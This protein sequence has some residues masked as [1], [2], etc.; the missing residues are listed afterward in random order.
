M[1]NRALAVVCVMLLAGFSFSA[2]AQAA[3]AKG[4]GGD[5]KAQ[6]MKRFDTNGDGQLSPAEKQAAMAARGGKPGA[7]NQGAGGDRKAQMMKRFDAN[8]DGQLSPAEK[9][10]AMASRGAAGGKPGAKRQAKK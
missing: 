2:M 7:G 1:R 10:A 5:R 9:Q 6:M 8:G 3:P 4:A